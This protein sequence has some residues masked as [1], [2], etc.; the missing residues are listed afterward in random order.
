VLHR[1]ELNSRV[2]RAPVDSSAVKL[3]AGGLVTKIAFGGVIRRRF[4][5]LLD[6]PASLHTTLESGA[7]DKAQP[8]TEATLNQF[9]KLIGPG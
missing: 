7:N 4:C 9:T 3:G 2:V 5:D 1:P 6:D 8:I